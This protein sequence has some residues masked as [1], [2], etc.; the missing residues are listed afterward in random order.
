MFDKN[1][2]RIVIILGLLGAFACIVSL[3][4]FNKVPAVD[5]EFPLAKD[6]IFDT[7]DKFIST[8]GIIAEQYFKRSEITSDQ[9]AVIYAQKALGIEKTNENLRYLPLYYWQ[10][11]YSKT[12]N[13]SIF[14]SKSLVKVF[15]NPINS[16]IIGL[17]RNISRE[18]YK[19]ARVL[20]REE[21]DAI[22]QDFFKLT[23]FN[24]SEF[25]FLKYSEAEN[26]SVY[27]WQKEMPGLKTAKLRVRLEI[28]SGTVYGFSYFLDIPDTEFKG[29]RIN[30]IISVFIFIVLNAIVFA[31]GLLVFFIFVMKRRVIKW[32][33]PLLFAFAMSISSL[34]E[35]LKLDNYKG[36]H[37]VLFLLLATV[38]CV[39]NFFWTL[40][41]SGVSKLL[42]DESGI[43]LFPEKAPAALLLS[44]VFFFCGLGFTM[45]CFIFVIKIFNPLSSVGFDSFFSEFPSSARS[46]LVVPLLSLGAAVFE[47]L[48]F[49]ALLISF[50]K[51]Y[52]KN[53]VLTI[54]L[55]SLI[56]SFMH[57]SPFGNSD[58]YPDF[59]KGILLLP[60]GI[61]FGY[62]LVKFGLICAMATH[63]IHDVFVIGL[64][65]SE[66]SNFRYVNESVIILAVAALLPLF[67]SYYLKARNHD[68]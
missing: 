6:K 49:R 12:A 46:Y 1:K 30:N 42:A 25:E 56:W 68:A 17:T 40:I 66:F 34:V 28:I 67:L 2:S 59:V 3:P 24:I 32:S 39:I 50:L 7:C 18:E 29:F 38:I 9:K 37:L 57:I 14:P 44:Y 36:M 13:K 43:D 19:D 55:S 45:L 64:A 33:I 20:S 4:L 58:I 16:K 27:E 15:V 62:I 22:A 47:E 65:F 23:N 5:F 54:I 11:E 31:L 8:Q 63:Y 35:L 21:I 26:K 61:L 48:F 10:V 53:T 60:I 41:V 51:K 52:M